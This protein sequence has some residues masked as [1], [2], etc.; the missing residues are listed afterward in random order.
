MEMQ[1]WDNGDYKT[2]CFE[3]SVP[4][5]S[6]AEQRFVELLKNCGYEKRWSYELYGYGGTFCLDGVSLAEFEYRF[7]KL[8]ENDRCGFTDVDSAI[9]LATTT[10]D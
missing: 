1:L 5:H 7:E 3:W 4:F 2:L 6:E 10:H 9:S 8:S